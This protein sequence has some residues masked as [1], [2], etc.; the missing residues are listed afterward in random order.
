MSRIGTIYTGCLAVADGF[1]LLSNCPEELQV[2][3]NLGH[4]FAG[5]R[6]YKIHPL[7]TTLVTRVSTKTNM[8]N[9]KNK[10]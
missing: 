9:D 5:E 6:R 4:R 10:E 8:I 3:F 1:L 2:M 7:K